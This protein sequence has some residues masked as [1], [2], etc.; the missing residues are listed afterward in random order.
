[1]N[2]PQNPQK[3]DDSSTDS[4]TF[5]KDDSPVTDD[6]EN[7]DTQPEEYEEQEENQSPAPT[8]SKLIISYLDD[9]VR[10]HLLTNLLL[11]GLF[12]NSIYLFYHDYDTNHRFSSLLMMIQ[13]C[14][15]T[16]FFLIRIAPAKVSMK[17]LD[18]GMAVLGT[19]LPMLIAPVTADN[20]VVILMLLQFF[21]IF[22]ATIATISLNTSFAIVPAIRNIKTGGLYSIIRH[23]IY[24]SYFLTFTCVVLQNFSLV[25]IVVLLALYAT[26]IYRIKAEEKI[27]SEDPGYDLYKMRVRYRLIPFVW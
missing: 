25:N 18:W 24:F 9:L 17:P 16:L 7:H 20:E 13:V 19:C 27:L 26:D 10:G 6:H 2:D 11:A 23:P 14:C 1:M 5:P 8:G 3:N 22:M 12:A 15:I 21:G 4:D